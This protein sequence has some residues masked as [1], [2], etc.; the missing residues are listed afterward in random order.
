MKQPQALKCFDIP[1]AFTLSHKGSWQCDEQ[2]GGMVTWNGKEGDDLEMRVVARNAF[3]ATYQQV[4]SLD[5]LVEAI[6]STLAQEQIVGPIN[7]LSALQ[8]SQARR[9]TIDRSWQTIQSELQPIQQAIKA[10]PALPDTEQIHWAQSVLALRN[11]AFMEIDTTGLQSEDEL[12][13]FTLVDKRGQTIEDC[14][15][16][17][18]SRVLTSSVSA[19]NGITPEQLEQEGLELPTTWKHI[20]LAVKGRYI[21]SYGQDWDLKV[22]AQAAARHMLERLMIIGDDLQ[23]HCTQYYQREYYLKLAALCER[24]NSP[25]PEPPGQTALDRAKGQLAVLSGIASSVTDLRPVKPQTTIT[26][27]V[28]NEDDDPLASLDD[29]PF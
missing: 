4:K 7:S 12:I 15:I 28:T 17:P 10:L 6:K 3:L 5:Q 19:I 20:Q 8:G 24:M 11:L 29:H 9:A 21:I 22:L 1:F 27:D 18:A 13:R 14:L 25:L 16:K 23:R 2:H 26:V